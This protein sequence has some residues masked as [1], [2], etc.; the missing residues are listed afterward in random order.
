MFPGLLEYRSDNPVCPTADLTIVPKMFG[1]K[2]ESN[3][4]SSDLNER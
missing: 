1:A 3:S 2:S 4:K